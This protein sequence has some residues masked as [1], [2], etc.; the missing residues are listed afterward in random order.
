MH[1]ERG[2]NHGKNSLVHSNVAQDTRLSSSRA[3]ERRAFARSHSPPPPHFYYISF[4]MTHSNAQSIALTVSLVAWEHERK[5]LE[6]QSSRL[7]RK[8][9]Q[10]LHQRKRVHAHF[11]E[12]IEEAFRER[13]RRKRQMSLVTLDVSRENDEEIQEEIRSIVRIV[14]DRRGR[15]NVEEKRK[16]KKEKEKDAP[17]KRKRVSVL[18][19]CFGPDSSSSDRN[20]VS[21]FSSSSRVLACEEEQFDC[22]AESRPL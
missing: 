10:D 16:K 9:H 21:S 6:N 7:E 3:R 4:R 19:C 17:A 22:C 12:T 2:P 18:C 14:E 11:D 5:R 13:R 20:V 15:K 8:K 1:I